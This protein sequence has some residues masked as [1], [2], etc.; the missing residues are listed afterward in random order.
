MTRVNAVP[1]CPGET[2][3][4]SDMSIRNLDCLYRPR[5]VAVIGA[6]DRE[7]TVGAVLTRNLLTAGFE[8]RVMLVNPHH[9]RI[10]GRPVCP[11]VGDLPET[12]DLAVITTPADA[13]PG[14]VETLAGRGTR[15]AVII[16][17]GFAESGEHGR[18]LQQAVLDAARPR[19]LRVVG[20]NCLGILVPGVGLNASFAHVRPKTGNLAFV[21]QSGAIVTSLL[22]WAAARD[23]GFSHLVSLGDMADVDFGDMLDYLAGDRDTRAILLY[24]EAVTQARKFMSAARAAARSKPVIVVKAGRH[25]EGARAAA[26]HTGALAGAD[27]VYDAAFRRAGMLRVRTMEE[28]FEAAE[29]LALAR[30]PRGDRVAILTN[31]GGMGVMATDDLVDHGGRLAELT[32]ETLAALDE[33]LPGTW[34][35]ANPVDIIGDAPGSRYA[36]ALAPLVADPGVQ[37]LLVLNCPTAVASAAEAADSV[38]A[39][40]ARHDHPTVVTSWVGEHTARAARETFRKARIPTYDTPGEAV[41]AFMHMVEFRRN[42]ESLMETPPSV[43]ERFD[44]DV[45]TARAVVSGALEEGR[46]WLSHDEVDRL[47]Q[48]Y[49]I[50]LLRASAAA[51]PDEAARLAAAVDA[52]VALKIRSPDIQHKSDVGGVA[53]DLIGADAVREAAEAMRE[54]VAGKRPGARLEGFTVEPMVPQRGAWELIVGISDDPLFGPVILFGQGGT[55]VEVIND[56]ALGL[57]PL[58]MH[59]ACEMMSR[60]RIHRLLRGG[61]GQPPADIPAI[62]L[63]LIKL[64]QLAGD[65]P[66]VAELD[67]NPLRA[68][69][70]GVLSLDARVR[71]APA[72]GARADRLAIRPY[73]RELVGEVPLGDGRVLT[74]RPIMPEDEPALRESF[75]KLNREEMRL[76]FFVP[77]KALSHVMGA[78]FTQI[79]YDREMTLVLTGP[80]VP[81]EAEIFATAQL[82]ADPDNERAE[83]SILVRHDITGLGLGPMLMRRLIEH[84]RR[85]GI[86]E[87]WGDVLAENR[88]MLNL[89][90][91]LGFRRERVPEDPSLVRVRLDL[92]SRPATER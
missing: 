80:G 43:P 29:I 4:A 35:R 42:Q 84:A 71:V 17:A 69:A 59:L 66:E 11:D 78:R 36:A 26:S 72:R 41:R 83:Y 76:R 2:G 44:P 22:D 73:P 20:P 68:C 58:N 27:A 30:P 70:Q 87:I 54:H 16:G 28:L 10:L 48:A 52:P 46:E 38:T 32:P 60:T 33:V 37:G 5:S 85:R 88:V 9:E 86:R 23:I 90:K 64:A 40:L 3:A 62:A 51:T 67:I 6:S 18:A 47:L 45:G 7:G 1:D 55:A 34:S 63:T 92:D 50:P 56:R 31:G 77:F 75:G 74:L 25:E 91:A 24:V 82:H 21:A 19:L 12:P 57:P 8:A 89:C 81:G 53:L 13:V 65:V 61:R 14:I 15:A 39:F 79:D 49:C